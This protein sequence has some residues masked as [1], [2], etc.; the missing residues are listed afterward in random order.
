MRLCLVLALAVSA[1]ASDFALP[2]V[3]A[4]LSQARR[5][6]GEMP[7]PRPGAGGPQAGPDLAVRVAAVL[8]QIAKLRSIE[9][10]C[11]GSVPMCP[12]DRMYYEKA[13]LDAAVASALLVLPA[14]IKEGDLGA[15]AG[16]VRRLRHSVLFDGSRLVP[17][18][19]LLYAAIEADALIASAESL[20]RDPRARP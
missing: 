19:T 9:W 14:F 6:A 2:S 20:L 12:A 10:T 13:S 5:Q 16:V 3:G 4:A 7:S 8:A 17:R 15:A 1:G 11:G 18:G